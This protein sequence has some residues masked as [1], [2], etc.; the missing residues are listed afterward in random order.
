MKILLIEDDEAVRNCIKHYL[1]RKGHT[2]YTYN[3]GEGAAEYA[4]D[5]CPDVKHTDRY[6]EPSGGIKGV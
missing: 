5:L 6:L 4:M 1:E 3:R 2:V